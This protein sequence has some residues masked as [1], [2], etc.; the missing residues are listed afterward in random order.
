MVCTFA[1][2]LHMY[3]ASPERNQVAT[4][5]IQKTG[6]FVSAFEDLCLRTCDTM[7]SNRIRKLYEPALVLTL[8]VGKVKDLLGRVPLFSCLFY[9]NAAATIP[10]KYEHARSRPSNLGV[11]KVRRVHDH[12]GAVM[13]M[14][15][16]PGCGTSGDPS[17]ELEEFQS[18]KQ[19]ESAERP[20]L[21]HPCALGRPS[22]LLNLQE[23]DR[24]IPGI[25]LILNC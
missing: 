11:L 18:Q 17:L 19:K 1:A 12:A 5:V 13:F 9:G 15:S 16:T 8:Y 7:E 4:T 10:Y 14:R 25:P 20:S 2:L 24:C 22:M 23:Y 3:C 21:K 6:L